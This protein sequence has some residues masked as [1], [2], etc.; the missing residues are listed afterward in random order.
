[1]DKLTYIS[2]SVYISVL[3]YLMFLTDGSNLAN[4]LYVVTEKLLICSLVYSLLVREKIFSKKIYLISFFIV[5]LLFILYITLDYSRE[6]AKNPIAI[7][8]ACIILI[9]PLLIF[10]IINAWQMKK[11]HTAR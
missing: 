10:L 9:L 11:S 8:I 6:F 7:L 2:I 5:Q 4:I 3:C 1:M